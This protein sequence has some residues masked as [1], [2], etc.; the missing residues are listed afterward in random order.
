V[1]R[2]LQSWPPAQASL[3]TVNLREERRGSKRRRK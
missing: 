2:K 3:F 1:W